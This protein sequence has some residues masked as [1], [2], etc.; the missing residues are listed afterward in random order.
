MVRVFNVLHVFI[1]K[2]TKSDTKILLNFFFLNSTINLLFFIDSFRSSTPDDSE[3]F[4]RQNS[5]KAYLKEKEREFA[6][7]EEKKKALEEKRANSAKKKRDAEKE[8]KGKRSK[9][10]RSSAKSRKS[11]RETEVVT[12]AGGLE[13]AQTDSYFSVCSC[14]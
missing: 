10:P 2:L 12:P 8:E 1:T 4:I 14:K 13:Q 3:P 11:R 7:E 9:S 6:E 5:I